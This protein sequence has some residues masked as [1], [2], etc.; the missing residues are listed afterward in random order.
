MSRQL[1]HHH[2]AIPRQHAAYFFS[3]SASFWEPPR[4]HSLTIAARH[5]RV[6][7]SITESQLSRSDLAKP[8]PRSSDP[9][10]EERGLQ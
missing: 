9:D 7:W 6:C 10:H 1:C 2:T 5:G 4:V 3:Q 8:T